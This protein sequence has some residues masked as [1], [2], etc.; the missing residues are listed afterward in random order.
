MERLNLAGPYPSNPAVQD[1]ESNSGT[2]IF[3]SLVLDRSSFARLSY[4]EL[5][6]SPNR[7]RKSDKL[8][9]LALPS[10]VYKRRILDSTYH[11]VSP[12]GSGKTSHELGRV[13][14]S[15]H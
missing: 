6:S 5:R 11:R 8:C 15:C 12:S 1:R 3:G 14:C 13:F 10:N 9:P 4:G 7:D 2:S